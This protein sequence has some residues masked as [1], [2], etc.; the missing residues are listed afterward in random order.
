M[1]TATSRRSSEM[2]SSNDKDFT[3]MY[4]S[5]SRD[6]N[7][8]YDEKIDIHPISRSFTSNT[9]AMVQH[10]RRVG[11][12]TIPLF[13]VASF[14][15][16][17]VVMVCH[18]IFSSVVDGKGVDEFAIR[19]SW[20][21]DLGNA[22]AQI[23][24][25][26]LQASVGVALTQTI[27]FY[28]RRS[29]MTLP[30]LDN[31]FDLPSMMSIPTLALTR[32]SSSY[33]LLLAFEIQA[34]ALIGIFAPN[35]LSV[36]PAGQRT[37]TL[38]VPSAAL[39]QIPIVDSAQAPLERVHGEIPCGNCTHAQYQSPSRIFRT[40][41]QSVLNQ[42]DILP[43][44]APA[45]CGQACNYT[46]VYS[47]PAL[48]CTDVSQS[49]F[50]YR[51]EPY[52]PTWTMTP[53]ATNLALTASLN[54]T[55]G[56]FQVYNA[57]TT[58]GF[59]ENEAY[60]GVP[61]ALFETNL[62]SDVY[63]FSVMYSANNF[64]A[65]HIPVSLKMDDGSALGGTSCVF[66]NATYSTDVNFSNG[67]HA[68]IARVVEYGQPYGS[69][70]SNFG[71]DERED[72][73]TVGLIDAMTRYLAGS[74]TMIDFADGLV[75][76]YTQAFEGTG[77]F[78]IT[79]DNGTSIALRQGTSLG[80]TLQDLCTNLTASLMSDSANLGIRTSVS[81]TVLPN[82]NVYSY[83]PRRLWLVYGI[84][85]AAALLADCFGL[86]CMRSSGIA[87]W[88][89]FSTI[90]ASMRAHELNELLSGPEERP[91]EAAGVTQ[92]R[93]RTGMNGEGKESGF[94]IVG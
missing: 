68:A 39:D 87:L 26:L 52:P 9:V 36:V 63:A 70:G 28:V 72:Y 86:A 76:Y 94:V 21:R 56:A 75:S 33:V 80:Q 8:A 88:R 37:S 23:A 14:L 66:L 85:L 19:Q 50:V 12:L 6:D 25:I 34:F 30:E 5:V 42:G 57:T 18:H 29:S 64:T 38:L 65:D 3:V 53:N 2:A 45:G 89:S 22:L 20:V 10:V 32:F 58:L 47:G 60:T 51:A 1:P 55:P 67:S 43:W 61:G 78:S 24:Q 93:Y 82:R 17:A 84:A 91:R 79:E 16:A 41:A 46:L 59:I 40:L 27:W 11:A 4:S 83:Q 73:A 44:S 62:T 48:Q 69:Y 71:L 35:A 15:A 13:M 92:L 77:L 54:Y 81:A 31:L 49:S 7:D 74:V 90:A